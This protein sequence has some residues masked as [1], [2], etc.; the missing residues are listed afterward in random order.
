MSLS[1]GSGAVPIPRSG[2]YGG[3]R[4]PSLLVLVSGFLP[5][6]ETPCAHSILQRL[7]EN[8]CAGGVPGWWATQGW[9]FIPETRASCLIVT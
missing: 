9:G 6:R 8:I 4:K 1:L 7:E 3:P 5:H 2:A